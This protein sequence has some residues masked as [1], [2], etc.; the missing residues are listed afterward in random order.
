MDEML[1]ALSVRH[2]HQAKPVAT[3]HQPHGLGVDG[4]RPIGEFH[5]GGQ[6]VLMQMDRQFSLLAQALHR[7]SPAHARLASPVRI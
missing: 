6:V 7:F 5:L 2:L 4:D 3:G 1:V